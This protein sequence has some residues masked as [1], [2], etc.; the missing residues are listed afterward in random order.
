MKSIPRINRHKNQKK[1]GNF[2][3]TSW[4][5]I[6]NWPQANENERQ[7]SL[8]RFF[9]DYKFPL[10]NF[11]IMSGH[12]PDEAEDL[13]QEFV[14]WHIETGGK[15][16]SAA[17]SRKGRFRNLLLSALKRFIIDEKRK[18][19]AQ[20]RSPR[21]G[22]VHFDSMAGTGVCWGD[23]VAEGKTPEQIFENA[24]LM[25]LLWNVTEQLSNAFQKKGQIIHYEIFRRRVIDPIF[26]GTVKP[27]IRSI[28]EHHDISESKAGNYLVTAKRAYRRFLEKEIRTYVASE[29]EVT[30]EINNLFRFLQ[31]Q[32]S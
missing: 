22:I 32:E 18:L 3:E 26:S 31:Q 11:I 6:D 21:K 16:F 19:N 10:I 12:T 17:D 30:L 28:A 29:K 1:Q 9:N 24:W 15:L 7:R 5:D 4:T 27:S 2:P 25:T 14:T 23:F 13:F 8:S 20:K